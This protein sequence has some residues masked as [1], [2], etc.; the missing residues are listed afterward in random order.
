M[1]R[2]LKMQLIKVVR[3]VTAWGGGCVAPAGVAAGRSS[4]RLGPFPSGHCA[5]RRRCPV[6]PVTWSNWGPVG[7]AWS[8]LLP[9][10]GLP[11]WTWLCSE[12]RE[13]AA[14]SHVSPRADQPSQTAFGAGA[15]PVTPSSALC[16]PPLLPLPLAHR[17]SRRGL[18]GGGSWTAPSLCSALLSVLSALPGAR[19]RPAD[20]RLPFRFECRL[21]AACSRAA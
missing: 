18:R 3:S 20:S 6:L 13:P 12:Q 19:S 15:L 17:R 2:F 5:V 1:S 11:G 9:A 16:F 8:P 14:L 7:S 10:A 4:D 21:K